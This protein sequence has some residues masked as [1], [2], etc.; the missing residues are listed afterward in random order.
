MRLSVVPALLIALWYLLIWLVGTTHLSTPQAAF[1]RMVVGV[2]E[3][4]LLEGLRITGRNTI[5]AA[6]ISA[7]IGIPLG[8]A[9]GSSSFVA[10]IME[11]FLVAGF[12]TPKLL[13]WPIVLLIF[14]FTASTFILFGVM[15]GLLP[16]LLFTMAAAQ[17][18]SPG[19]L[20][21]AKSLQLSGRRTFLYITLPSSIG[22]VLAG[23]KFGLSLCFL[24]VVV[25]EMLLNIGGGEAERILRAGGL[26]ALVLRAAEFNNQA[27]LFGLV[28]VI[29][30]I[31]LSLNGLMGAIQRSVS[32]RVGTVEPVTP[33]VAP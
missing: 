2:Q 25:A 22:H 33:G 20:K 1:N 16:V 19:V 4:W 27:M 8:Y 11:P 21:V 30:V 28:V 23:L 9:M 14:G 31:A 7:A 12:S 32:R 3:G 29:L 15:H 13:L 10:T 26:G 5:I 18:V 24:G 17:G 6:L